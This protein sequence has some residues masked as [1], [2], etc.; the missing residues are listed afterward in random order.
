VRLSLEVIA[1]HRLPLSELR[2]RLKALA[3][4]LAWSRHTHGQVIDALSD[5]KRAWVL[6]VFLPH[7]MCMSFQPRSQWAN[8]IMKDRVSF[9][10]DAMRRQ[11]LLSPN[12][13]LQFIYHQLVVACPISSSADCQC[14]G[15]Y[16]RCCS[17]LAIACPISSGESSC[18]LWR[19]G[20]VTSL[21]AGHRRQNAS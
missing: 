17:Q 20:T 18:R 3:S 11:L 7:D 8:C 19:P 21:C 1:F 13:T 12:T 2:F 5:Q 6:A 14:L 10:R 9:S 15:N 4:G 16:F